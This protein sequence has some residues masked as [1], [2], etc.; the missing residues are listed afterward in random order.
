MDKP[1]LDY[2]Y[3][4]EFAQVSENRLTV[5]GA[6]FTHVT[7]MMLPAPHNFYVAGRIRCP[8]DVAGV[9]LRIEVVPPNE[10]Y[11]IVG[12]LRIEHQGGVRP[13][14][15]KVGLLFAVGMSVPIPTV[16]LYE[17][18]I[19]VEGERARRLAFDVETPTA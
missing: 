13:Y 10:E 18:L 12:D 19:D 7:A 9:D 17:I 4:A 11:Q 15:G 2:A 1:E 5:V 16:G 14:N 8:E 6:S 3:L